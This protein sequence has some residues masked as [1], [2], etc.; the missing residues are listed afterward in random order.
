MDAKDRLLESYHRL[1]IAII[2]IIVALLFIAL[3]YVCLG[4]LDYKKAMYV[5]LGM[6]ESFAPFTIQNFMW[7][8]FWL[9]VGEIWMRLRSIKEEMNQLSKDYLHKDSDRLFEAREAHEIVL[10]LK[11][12]AGYNDHFLPRFII[13]VCQQ[14]QL[15]QASDE[16]HAV[17]RTSM[18]LFD[19]EIE[20]RYTFIRYVIWLIPTLGFIGT[21]YGISL[22]LGYAGNPPPGIEPESEEFLRVITEKLGVAF[23]TTLLALAQSAG[24]V[25]LQNWTQSKEEKVLNHSMQYCVDSLINKLY[26]RA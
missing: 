10:R 12:Q 20:L 17:L 5:L 23:Y 21:I 9:C 24:L 14:Y 19:H 18:E 4:S 6:K 16:A 7:I 3:L 1:R 15:T 8:V 25:W 26:K 22:A 13:R 11:G 2:F